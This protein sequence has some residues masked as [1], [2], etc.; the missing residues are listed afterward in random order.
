MP[1]AAPACACLWLWP[2]TCRQAQHWCLYQSKYYRSCRT[3]LHAPSPWLMFYHTGLDLLAL[4]HT[5]AGGHIFPCMQP[6]SWECHQGKGLV[7]MSV[8][9][10][11]AA[12]MVLITGAGVEERSGPGP[13]GAVVCQGRER[14]SSC[15]IWL[16]SSRG[17]GPRRR[18]RLAAM[19]GTSDRAA[20]QR[21]GNSGCCT[22][23][24]PQ[25]ALCRFIA[26]FL[27]INLCHDS[28]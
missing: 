17:P 8:F 19:E 24:G 14:I 6:T 25:P 20:G 12:W 7:P 3:R 27:A 1:A 21:P 5:A 11:T 10:R 15:L 23:R 4:R 22:Y 16:P 28:G 9:R 18:R 26:L 13:A 2:H